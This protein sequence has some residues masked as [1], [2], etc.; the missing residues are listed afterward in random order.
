MLDIAVVGAHSAAFLMRCPR[1]P[2]QGEFILAHAFEPTQDGGKG[3]NQALALARLGARSHLVSVVGDDDAGRAFL[4]HFA[5]SGVDVD[6]VHVLPGEK[7]AVGI[8]FIDPAGQIIGATDP[9]AL[10]HFGTGEVDAARD[11]IA[12]SKVL[13]AQLE[14]PVEAALYA[15]EVGRQAGCITILNP[16]PADDV[17]LN[18]IHDVDILTPNEPEAK[19]LLG[20]SPNAEMPVQ[21]L[22]GLYAQ[23]A[24]GFKTVI[25]L[26]EQ[27]ALVIDEGVI[28]PIPCPR[29]IPVDTSGAGDCF[30]AALALCVGQGTPLVQAATF[31][32]RVASVSV[33]RHAVW[34]SYPTLQ[35]LEAFYQTSEEEA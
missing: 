30:N 1:L 33:T 3:S 35:E 10:A 2:T 28:T 13:L 11:I 34:P 17:R 23:R 32:A 20:L 26:G 25:T 9:G 31:A 18:D 16:A 4:A 8:A 21:E 22:A 5:Q 14:I 7:T 15:C 27:G 12:Q 29:V 19:L 6:K 24:P